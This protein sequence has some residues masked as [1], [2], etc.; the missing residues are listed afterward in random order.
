MLDPS[1]ENFE[2]LGHGWAWGLVTLAIVLGITCH[3]L[4]M[5]GL[6][7]TV[8]W[9]SAELPLFCMLH[10]V[11]S[12][13]FCLILHLVALHLAVLYLAVLYLA[14]TAAGSGVF[15]KR[16]GALLRRKRAYGDLGR[17]SGKL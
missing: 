8:M 7:S 13:W 16:E 14:S 6:S 5:P 10:I 17:T 1:I 12:A 15:Q 9:Q 4:V 2:T 11:A 3:T